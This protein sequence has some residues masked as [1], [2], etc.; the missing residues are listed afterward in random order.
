MLRYARNTQWKDERL[1]LHSPVLT[2]EV[3][4]AREHAMAMTADDIIY[5]R[6]ALGATGRVGAE[7]ETRI[8]KLTS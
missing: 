1:S 6:T 8:Q 2:A 7:T 5:R 3:P 4:Y